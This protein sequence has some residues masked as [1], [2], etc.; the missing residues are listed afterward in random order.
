MEPRPEAA[1]TRARHACWPDET[2]PAMEPRP[3][4][5]GDPRPSRSPSTAT[6]SRNGAAAVR[7]RIRGREAPAFPWPSLRNGAAARGLRIPHGDI[8]G[9]GMDRTGAITPEDLRP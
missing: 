7:P 8:V 9:R 5:H 3:E 1:D 6:P 4:L 2:R